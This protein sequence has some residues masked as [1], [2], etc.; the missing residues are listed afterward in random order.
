MLQKI[1][2]P[3]L[4]NSPVA[5]VLQWC[6]SPRWDSSMSIPWFP[7]SSV[8]L[9]DLQQQVT[10]LQAL[11]QASRQVHS[12][13]RL[14]EVLSS[15]LRIIGRELE[16]TG[17][18]FTKPLL[19]YGEMPAEPCDNCAR[20]LIEGKDGAGSTEL[21]VWPGPG[22]TMSIYEQDFLD[23]LV[24]QA[25]V[26]IE[27]AHYHERSME[28]ARVQQDLDA[29]RLIQRSLLPQKMPHIPGYS[30]AARS[31]ACYEVGGDYVDL[32]GLADG[33][34]MMVLADV[35]GKGLASAIV[36]SAFRSAFRASAAAALSLDEM[37]AHL[38][39]QHFAEGAEARQRYVTAIFLKF[40][41]KANR[42]EV[43]NAGHN[44]AFLFSADGAVLEIAASGTPIGLVPAMSYSVEA[45]P[46]LPGSRL[47][48]Y[49]DGL[50]EVFR[51]DEEFGP[52]R[53]LDAFLKC[54]GQDA[55]AILDSLWQQI[56]QFS[57]GAR[58][59]D[60]MSALALV[61]VDPVHADIVQPE[62]AQERPHG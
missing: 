37:A 11:L 59:Y 48:F 55:T 40:D 10:R 50:T 53:L 4:R 29:A 62:T 34:Q 14:E 13:L 47:L 17:A 2:S 1:S 9:I 42:I 5:P 24:L 58:Q 21:V 44:P 25:T 19:V 57:G 38:N 54:K 7:A 61:H 60:D 51:G 39:Q 32:V 26:A 31:I 27:N 16:M 56:Q 8:E 36:S 41:P 52:E 18:L 3:C 49:T 22:R 6:E 12:A 33:L 35:A 28:W 15:V 30:V 43:V 46:F 20:F 23:G 45:H